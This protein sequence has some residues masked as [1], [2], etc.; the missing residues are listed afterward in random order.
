MRP[1][2]A[3]LAAARQF[4]VVRATAAAHVDSF[5]G[6]SVLVRLVTQQNVS[7]CTQSAARCSLLVQYL[8]R[9]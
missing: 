3:Q 2:G 1:F 6:A 9:L 8:L 5:L 7:S 4:V